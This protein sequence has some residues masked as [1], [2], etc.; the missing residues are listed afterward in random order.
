MLLLLLIKIGGANALAQSS[1]Q[2]GDVNQAWYTAIR[3]SSS[4]SASSAVLSETTTL[5]RNL[6]NGAEIF[7]V[8][9]A[10]V[11]RNSAEEVRELIRVVKPTS[12][13]VEL[14]EAR[15]RRIRASSQLQEGDFAKDLVQE[16]LRQLGAGGRDLPQQFIK[17]GMQGFYRLLKS[18]GM[19]PGLEF[20]VAMEEAELLRA[21]I[22]FGDA[23]QDRTM[24]RISESLTVQGLLSM[25]MGGGL[26]PAEVLDF[27]KSNGSGKLSDQ[28]EAMKNRKMARA[29][30]DYMRKVNP[31][32]ASALTDERDEYMVK[33]LQQLEGRI[34]G[35]VGLAHLDG[36]ERRWD[37]IQNKQR[38]T[39]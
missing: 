27:L 3:K 36:I 25:V 32:L 14:C 21:R 20:K 7:L 11:S 28:V 2:N 12:V 1:L 30:T 23:D 8:G 6:N 38:E 5:L 37:A 24:R 9:T 16:L 15:A 19:D 4:T 33:C 17:M 35:V 18:L 34:V 31:E 26:P 22:V 39:S 13:M 10:H 29:M